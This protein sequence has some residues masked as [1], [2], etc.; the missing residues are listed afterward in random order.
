MAMG[1]SGDGAY[2]S[3]TTRGLPP[4]S[5]YDHF[6]DA[7]ADVYVGVRPERPQGGFP[8]DFSLFALQP[9]SL[10]TISTPGTSAHRDRAS[11]ARLADDALFLNHSTRGWGLRQ[12]GREWDVAGRAAIV[13]DNERPFDVIADPRRRLD[14]TSVRVPRALLSA[15]TR[16]AI[17]SLDETLARTPAGAQLG[18]QVGMLTSAARQGM[19]S[20]AT[21]MGWVLVEMLDAFASSSPSTPPPRGAVLRAYA[22]G[23]L[24]DPALT[25][26]ALAR[27]FACS[28]RT[29]QA[30]FAAD[31]ETFSDWL[32]A[33]RLDAARQMLRSPVASGRSIAAVAREH[34]FTDAGTFH[35]AYRARFGRTPG[36]DR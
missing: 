27:A 23:R 26:P 22:R 3:G 18:A 36:A 24:S 7:I 10:G 12:D 9:F 5:D 29:V 30:A 34:G 11:I 17:S 33:E 16:G 21:A 2:A 32:R 20:V 19:T 8:A 1:E 13:L 25:L 6:C 15:R 35:R 31:G 4:G 14:L 28:T